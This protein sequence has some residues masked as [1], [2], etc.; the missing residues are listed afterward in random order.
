V[1][2]ERTT[3]ELS[4]QLNDVLDRLEAL[5]TRLDTQFVTKEVFG[6][7]N[8][9]NDEVHKSL[10]SDVNNLLEDKKWL[11]RFVAGII[12]ATLLGTIIYTNGGG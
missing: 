2:G 8:K 1:T 10:R 6:Y 7:Q 5:A 4:R 11:I 3:A 9:L 12:I